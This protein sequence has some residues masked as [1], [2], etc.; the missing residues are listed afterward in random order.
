MEIVF[1]LPQRDYDTPRPLSCL[2]DE[3]WQ[4]FHPRHSVRFSA[5]GFCLFFYVFLTNHWDCLFKKGDLPPHWKLQK[6]AEMPCGMSGWLIFLGPTASRKDH[7]ERSSEVRIAIAGPKDTQT[8]AHVL[9]PGRHVQTSVMYAVE[10]RHFPNRF[11]VTKGFP[12]LQNCT[13]LESEL[14]II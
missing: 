7:K 5:F 6:Q 8:D 4:G 12:A 1:H 13:L 14:M 9:R 11:V 2:R 3:G 10:D